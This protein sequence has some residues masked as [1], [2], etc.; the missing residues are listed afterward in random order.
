M[1]FELIP[2][3][4]WLHVFIKDK[5]F[6]IGCR[7]EPPWKWAGDRFCLLFDTGSKFLSL[8]KETS[9]IAIKIA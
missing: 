3:K 4:N 6:F 9:T 5:Y 1:P 2:L 7:F 8:E